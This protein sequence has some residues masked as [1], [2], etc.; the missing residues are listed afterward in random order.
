MERIIN[1]K[2]IDRG[3]SYIHEALNV[4]KEELHQCI[5]EVRNYPD[6]VFNPEAGKLGFTEEEILIAEKNYHKITELVAALW[7]G[8]KEEITIREFVLTMV[9]IEKT[10]ANAQHEEESLEDSSGDETMKILSELLENSGLIGKVVNKSV[11]RVTERLMKLVKESGAEILRDTPA[12]EQWKKEHDSDSRGCPGYLGCAKI[13]ILRELLFQMSS[14]PT[15]F[16]E[17]KIQNAIWLEALSET[18]V[19]ATKILAAKD[20]NE[21][22]R[23]LE[24]LNPTSKQKTKIKI[25]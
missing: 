23:F 22:E 3:K 9:M 11:D 25:D 14:H 8:K 17:S 2:K 19:A 1:L 12:C 7:Q 21:L 6:S 4:P 15:R 16:A 20:I 18:L 24:E 13:L 5:I 10:L